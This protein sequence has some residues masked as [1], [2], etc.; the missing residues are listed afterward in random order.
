MSLEKVLILEDSILT[1][2]LINGYLENNGFNIC[3]IAKSFHEATELFDTHEPTLLI[4]DIHLEGS[5]NGIEFVTKV[6]ETRPTTLIIFI[7]SNIDN[8]LLMKAQLTKPHAYLTKP[9]TEEQLITAIQMA[10]FRNQ[11]DH[12]SNFD[13]TQKDIVVLQMLGQGKSNKEIGEQLFI[14]HHTVDSRRRKILLK[15]DVSSINHALCIASNK[16]WF[17]INSIER[18]E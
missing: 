13:L 3:G 14:S 12:P 11:Q 1:A 17:N 10:V 9:F 5:K 6:K 15:L 18:Y 2:T 16:S 8:H 7:S 4:C